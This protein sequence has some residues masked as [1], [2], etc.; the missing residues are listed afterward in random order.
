MASPG[1]PSA[2]EVQQ[3]LKALSDTASSYDA[4]PE[5]HGSRMRLIGQ[6]QELIA[7]LTD[8]SDMGFKQIGQVGCCC[9]TMADPLYST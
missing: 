2:D 9:H 7:S 1:F 6:A 8:P 4:S 5:G 3:Q